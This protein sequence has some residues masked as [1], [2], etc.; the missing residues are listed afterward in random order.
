[1]RADSIRRSLRDTSRHLLLLGAFVFATGCSDSF[2]LKPA[3][4]DRV[5]ASPAALTLRAGTSARVAATLYAGSHT[6]P[7]VGSQW[8]SSNT[9]IASVDNSGTVTAVARG[10]GTITVR[11]QSTSLSV[12]IPFTVIGVSSITVNLSTATIAIGESLPLIASVN[13]DAGVT[14]PPTTWSS[15]NPAIV[16]VS[17]SGVITALTQGQTVV[18][19]LCEG[20]SAAVTV[21]V[22]RTAVARVTLN[23]AVLSL[24]VGQV[25]VFAPTARDSRDNVLSDRPTTWTSSN[26]AIAVINPTGTVVAVALGTTTITANVEGV[27][28][29]AMVTVAPLPD[30]VTA[31]AVSPNPVSM[32][33][34]Q[35]RTLTTAVTQPTGAPPAGITYGTTAPSVATMSSAGMVT[36]VGPGSATITVTATSAGNANFSAS[37]VTATVLVTVARLPMAVTALSVSP[38][39]VSA[40][41]GQTQSIAASVTQPS[42]APTASISYGTTTPSVATVSSAGVVTAVAAGSARITV[43]AASS[44]NASFAASSVTATIAV[45]VAS[46]G[47]P[48]IVLGQTVANLSSTTGD[49]L[50]NVAVPAGTSSLLVR[51]SG[52][53]GSVYLYLYQGS[54]P[55]GN[56][57]CSQFASQTAATCAVN[58]PTAGI[59]TVRVAGGFNGVTLEVNPTLP[60]IGLGQTVANL[61]SA[62]GDALYN[63]AV[64]AGTSSLLVRTSGGSGSV[65]L[66]LYQGSSPAGNAACSQFASQTAAT[67]AVNA[68]TAG[69]WTVR[70][71]GGFSG[72]SL[73]V[74][75]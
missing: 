43:T 41:V 37:S 49:A 1:M 42:G 13:V 40:I 75:R 12:D 62:T 45:T 25:G 21:T 8:T 6:I 10:A 5:V 60:T 55:A 63:V 32:G 36:A 72:V 53:S 33:V 2:L 69:I 30:A 28:A 23:P 57:A 52:G 61:S 73:D 67:C 7:T 39:S 51:T 17:T 19:A 24:S 18:T 56:A 66:Y 3:I 29:T 65:Y 64:P 58:A 74:N 34:G 47:I 70:V 11:P 31:V 44:G 22:I 16:S 14:P 15:S 9:A 59:W 46:S 26:P 38:S 50:Y 35:T 27:L 48:S 68:P 71:A 20:R 4:P 54:S